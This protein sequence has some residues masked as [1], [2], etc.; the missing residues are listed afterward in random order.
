MFWQEHLLRSMART[1]GQFG[2]PEDAFSSNREAEE[3]LAEVVRRRR[4]EIAAGAEADTPDVISQI[5]LAGTK[6]ELDEA[7]QVGLAH[8][9][10]SASTDAP[11]ALL[12]NCIA[13]LDK[14]PALQRYLRG[15]PAMVKNFVEETLRYDGPAKNLCRQTT[16]EVTIGGITIPPTLGSWFSWARPTATNASMPTPTPSTCSGPS[17]ATT[18]SSPSAKAS[19]PA[20]AHPSP[21]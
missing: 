11:A 6:G 21:G 3:H 15:N 5:L 18:R 20:W 7:E 19:T 12:T 14:F 8:L 10:L 17:P 9:V 2:I 1:V 13:V 16:A 4:E